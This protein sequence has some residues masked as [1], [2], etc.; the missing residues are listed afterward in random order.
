M[1]TRRW[2]ITGESDC[3]IILPDCEKDDRLIVAQPG[4]EELT[5]QFEVARPA[6]ELAIGIEHG[7]QQIHVED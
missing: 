3:R 5:G 6:V 2:E 4:K 7:G 1:R